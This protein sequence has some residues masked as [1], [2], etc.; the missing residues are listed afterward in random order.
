MK[1]ASGAQLVPRTLGLVLVM[2]M[3]VQSD[4]EY[5]GKLCRE[6]QGDHGGETL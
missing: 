4:G 6:V 2:V 5:R 1:Y 3:V